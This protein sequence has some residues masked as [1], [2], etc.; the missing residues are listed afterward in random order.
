MTNTNLRQAFDQQFSA[1]RSQPAPDV[2][3]RRDRLAR[4][5]R[6][7]IDNTDA[8]CAAISADFGGRSLS[9]TKLLELLPAVRGIHH[10]RRHVARW[11]KDERRPVD[12][13]FQPSKAWVRYE[14]LGVVGIISPWNYPLLLAVSPL[15]DAIAAGNCA[16]IKPSELTPAFSEL[17]ARL[18]GEHFAPEEVAVVPGDVELAKAFA[19]LPFDHLFFTGSTSVGRSVMRA[20]AENLTPVTLELG[21]KSPAIVAED[22]PLE[23]AV[24]SIAFGKF[25]NAGQT[26][27]APDYVLVPRDRIDDVAK[28]FLARAEEA[29][30][31]VIGN[32]DYSAIITARHR[33]RLVQA[34]DEVRKSGCEIL[35]HESWT[36]NSRQCAPTLVIDPPPNSLLMREEIFGPVLPVIGYDTLD[37]ALT[38]VNGKDRPLA[39]YLF[40]HDRKVQEEVLSRATSGG[41]T[42]NGTLLHI[43]QEGLPFG[44]IGPSGIGAYHGREGFKRLSHARAVYKVGPINGFEWFGP[45]W[46]LLSRLALR[47]LG[48]IR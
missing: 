25:V 47:L 29:Y 21:G 32:E 38:L 26:C 7:L 22:Y 23:K 9:E 45:P 15:T 12:L 36:Q 17:L 42:V 28:A 46:G 20:A 24:Q 33:D 30:P 10:A 37:E 39:L 11:M 31:G 3:L 18:I 34:L 5:E 27:I 8:I 1:S 14:P 4:L 40:T 6:L 19:A 13:V 43:A 35:S 41:V 44:G 48:G 2:P 16:L